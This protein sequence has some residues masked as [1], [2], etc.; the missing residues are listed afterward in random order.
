VDWTNE[1]AES[2]DPLSDLP[3]SVDGFVDPGKRY[4]RL[5]WQ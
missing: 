5:K 4:S 1:Y 3:D 2:L